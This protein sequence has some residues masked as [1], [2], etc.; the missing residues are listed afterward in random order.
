MSESELEEK[1]ERVAAMVHQHVD[2]VNTTIAMARRLG[3]DVTFCVQEPGSGVRALFDSA[4]EITE[5]E[6]SCTTTVYYHARGDL[7]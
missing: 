5:V 7:R 2:A 6:I 4:A 3:L 1:R